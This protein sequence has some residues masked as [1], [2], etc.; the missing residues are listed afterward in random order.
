MATTK[1]R[2]Q[3]YRG[4]VGMAKADE[5]LTRQKARAEARKEQGNMPFRFRLSPGD[6]TQYVVVDDAPEFYR[7]EH[8]LKNPQTGYW[9]TYTGCVKEW[10]NC[11]VCE[12]TQKESYYALYLTVIDFTEFKTRDGTKHAFSRKLLVVK[13]AQQKKFIR[14][15]NKAEKDGLTL[16]GAVF[17]VTRDGDKDS[18]IGNDIEYVE[19]MDE[20]ELLTYTRSWKDKEGK[21]HSEKCYEVIDYE[22]VFEE[23]DTDKLSA[24]MG[25]A[26]APGSRAH[27]D[28]ELRG[29]RSKSEDNDDDWEKADRKGKMSS[30]RGREE[31]EE[32]VEEE[33]PSRGART[34][35]G[36]DEEPEERPARGRRT[37]REEPEEPEE[38]A[39]PPARPRRGKPAEEEPE[40]RP[41]R[42]TTSRKPSRNEEDEPPFDEDEPTERKAPGVGRRVQ[43]RGRR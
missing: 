6:T 20:D 37:A 9:D 18:S 36:R 42:G 32:E 19:H 28:R 3:F 2:S 24:L 1:R 17:E 8:N 30:R 33:R 10:D 27:S 5:E 14:A 26:P 16:R 40:E 7:F 43:A 41:R 13:P 25:A 31:P 29:R 11:P 12:G 35:R 15:Y 23:P 34:R 39:E 22:A 21:K 38:E 4:E